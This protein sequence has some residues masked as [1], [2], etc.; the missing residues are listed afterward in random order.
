MY[1]QRKSVDSKEQAQNRHITDGQNALEDAAI[2]AQIDAA[3]LQNLLCDSQSQI[4]MVSGPY[5]KGG[6]PIRFLY[7]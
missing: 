2:R 4:A 1:R 7:V 3:Q 5:G 6:G